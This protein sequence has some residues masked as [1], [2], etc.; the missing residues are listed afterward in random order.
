MSWKMEA[1][2]GTTNRVRIV[3]LAMPTTDSSAG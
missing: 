1:N 3:T 2:L